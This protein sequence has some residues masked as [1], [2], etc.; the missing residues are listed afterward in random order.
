MKG[1][2]SAEI[3]EKRRSTQ[4]GR[5]PLF[6]VRSVLYYAADGKSRHNKERKAV[7]SF[8]PFCAIQRKRN[9]IFV[10]NIHSNARIMKFSSF[11]ISF[12]R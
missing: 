9:C 5:T 7:E 1:E 2:K 10:E 6:L 11:Q 8:S 12:R 3:Y 4:L